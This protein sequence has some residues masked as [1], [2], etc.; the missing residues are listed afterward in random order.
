MRQPNISVCE[1]YAKSTDC[2][3]ND[4][5]LPSVLLGTMQEASEVSSTSDGFSMEVMN[6]AGFCWVIMRMSVDFERMPKWKERFLVRTWNV[7]TDKLLWTRDYE[8]LDEEGKKIGAATS[9]WLVADFKTH[10][11][12]RPKTLIESTPAGSLNV[13]Y[14]ERVDLTSR[15]LRAPKLNVPSR[16][17]LGDPVITKFADYCELDRNNHVN[18]TRY[19]AWAIDAIYKYG[20]DPDLICSFD[21][22]YFSEV[23]AGQMVDIFVYK[24]ETD[25]EYYYVVGY[26]GEDVKV[27]AFRF[28]LR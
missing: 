19:A 8:I 7:G 6:N 26:I 16:K 27:Y 10:R 4:M 2:D 9:E 25:P 22:N 11:P 5:L 24:D 18:N 1:Y 28:K 17:E 13:D 21:I 12:I 23:H 15:E 3:I 14:L 20:I